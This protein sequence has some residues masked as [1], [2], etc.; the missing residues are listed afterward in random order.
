[1][2]KFLKF[3]KYLLLFFFYRESEAVN[4]NLYEILAN[5]A[6]HIAPEPRSIDH[7]DHYFQSAENEVAS[8]QSDQT[9]GAEQVQKRKRTRRKKKSSDGTN[10]KFIEMP[11]EIRDNPKLKKYWVN[12]YRL[13]SKYDEGIKLDAGKFPV[14]H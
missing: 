10:N 11:E 1:M 9:S 14:L 2:I 8:N 5:K 6:I 7:K 13:F 3:P 4:K 12:R